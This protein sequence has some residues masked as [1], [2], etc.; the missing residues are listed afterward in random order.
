MKSSL[1]LLPFEYRVRELV[2]RR[3]LQWSL[4]WVACAVTAFG[5]WWLKQ[6]RCRAAGQALEAAER[7]YLPLERLIRE[8]ETMRTELEQLH[9][10][11]TVLG[12]LLDERPVLT[13]IGLTSQSA[14][15]CNGRLVVRNMLF[16][17]REEPLDIDDRK[18]KTR[19]N[20]KSESATE[21]TE[22]WALVTLKGEAA[23][24]VAVAQFVVS[25]RDSGLFRRVELK[26]SVG[27]S[28]ADEKLRS[29]LVVCDI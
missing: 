5:V 12:R 2:R 9:A 17:R 27:K 21:K 18:A 4:V 7:S 25:L 14:R 10:K 16:E 8:S 26:S 3:L 1:N 24:N 28:S 19:Q 22:T 13:L 29:Y 23:D 20:D 6:S 11:G 15:Q